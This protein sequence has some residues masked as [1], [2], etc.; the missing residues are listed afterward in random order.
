MTLI[1]SLSVCNTQWVCACSPSAS[2]CAE[3]I[4]ASVRLEAKCRAC[5]GAIK[6]EERWLIVETEIS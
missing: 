6:S 3:A 5:C 1:A 4:F 2:M